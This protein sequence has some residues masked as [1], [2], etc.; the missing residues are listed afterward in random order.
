MSRTALNVTAVC[1]ATA[2]PASMDEST[3]STAPISIGI[4][5]PRN[6]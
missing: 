4:R 3:Y 2:M 1:A 6:A 5:Y